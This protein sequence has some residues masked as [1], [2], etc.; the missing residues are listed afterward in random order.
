M[1]ANKWGFTSDVL[2]IMLAAGAHLVIRKPRSQSLRSH[3]FIFSGDETGC[4]TCD[5]ES[6]L[7]LDV[8]KKVRLVLG[9]GGFTK[10]TSFLYNRSSSA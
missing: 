8:S 4:Q 2:I 9:M 1:L 6:F 10:E 7:Q 3:L 5:L